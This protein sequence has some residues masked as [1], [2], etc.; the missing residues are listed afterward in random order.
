[1][2]KEDAHDFLDA[3]R[4]GVDVS[5]AGIKEA[6]IAT[7]DLDADGHF[8]HLHS[9]SGTWERAQMAAHFAPA[10]IWDGIAA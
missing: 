8:V 6:L 7:G 1:M 2:T 5:M 4:D 3:A 9:P 10:G